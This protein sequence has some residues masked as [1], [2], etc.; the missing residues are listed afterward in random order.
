MS[1]SLVVE[2]ATLPR[3]VLEW[4]EAGQKTSG[5]LSYREENGKIVLERIENIDPAM[6]GRVRAN[7][8]QYRS[9]LRRLADS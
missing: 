9:T 6:L 7:I 5:V 2:R 3:Q 1:E 4:I 8:E